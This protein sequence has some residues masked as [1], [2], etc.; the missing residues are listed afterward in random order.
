[1]TAS[2]ANARSLDVDAEQMPHFW[3][4]HGIRPARLAVLADGADPLRALVDW[5]STLSHELV[6]AVQVLQ[7]A[8]AGVAEPGLR[9]HGLA[10]P[11]AAVPQRAGDVPL[12]VTRSVER[13]IAPSVRALAVDL[14]VTCTRRVLPAHVVQSPRLGSLELQSS[15]VAA[16]DERFEW[17]L[18]SLTDRGGAATP[19]SREVER[20]PAPAREKGVRPR[21]SEAFTAVLDDGVQRWLATTDA[22]G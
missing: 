21:T 15:P 16:Q 8:G 5:A 18:R 6:L 14:L 10:E 9:E 19:L 11:V 4:R 7:E 13:S 1:M 17:V 12:L 22:F 20:R 3:S 2:G